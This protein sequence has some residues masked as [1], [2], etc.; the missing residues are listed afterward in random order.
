MIFTKLGTETIN[1]Q[2]KDIMCTKIEMKPP[3]L[4]GMVGALHGLIL[5]LEN[6]FSSIKKVPGTPDFLTK[7]ILIT[8]LFILIFKIVKKNVYSYLKKGI[9]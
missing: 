4:A 8:T 9:T 7:K 2:N 6:S 5:K 3:G 1:I